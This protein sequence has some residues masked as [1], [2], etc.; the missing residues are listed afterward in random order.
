MVISWWFRTENQYKGNYNIKN[1]YIEMDCK[2]RG[3]SAIHNIYTN[4]IFLR[5]R[6]NKIS[7]FKILK[8]DP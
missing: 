5:S 4:K 3:L 2:S 8:T 6:M 7:T 1:C